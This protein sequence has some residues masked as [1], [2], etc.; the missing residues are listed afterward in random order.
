[1]ESTT[2]KITPPAI[3][4]T[5]ANNHPMLAPSP[6]ANYTTA[7]VLTEI[8]SETSPEPPPLTLG[9]GVLFPVTPSP[10]LLHEPS[11][12]VPQGGLGL[13]DRGVS[14]EVADRVHLAVHPGSA[15]GVATVFALQL[16]GGD[17]QCSAR[18]G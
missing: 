17:E 18:D 1:M 2:H 7:R 10:P 5:I 16:L 8:D 6:E 13:G 3:S 12:L 4:P 9:A 15:D 14:Q 11:G